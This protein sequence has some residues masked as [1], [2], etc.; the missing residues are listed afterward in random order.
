LETGELSARPGAGKYPDTDFLPS[1]HRAREG[2][3]WQTIVTHDYKVV[4]VADTEVLNLKWAVRRQMGLPEEW[5]KREEWVDYHRRQLALLEKANAAPR[6][7]HIYADGTRCR[8]PKLRDGEKCY[9]HDRMDAVRPERL[10]LPAL[11]DANSVVLAVMEIQR[12]LLDG[13]ISEKTAG[14]LLYSV[15]IGA[16][17]VQHVTFK[18]VEPEEMVRSTERLPKSPELK[19][20]PRSHVIARDGKT[21]P[22]TFETRR[23]GGSGGLRR[24]VVSRSDEG[25]TH[26]RGSRADAKSWNHGGHRGARRKKRPTAD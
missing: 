25:G 26:R 17:A 22:K 12:A 19:G 2:D 7:Q 20:S 4:K 24:R 16:W 1:V 23:N 10:R 8:G 11:E 15:Q 21:K 6:C 18:E 13:L 5:A 9:A 14:L 3:P